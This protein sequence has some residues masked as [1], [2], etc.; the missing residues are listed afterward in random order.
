M[1]IK[2]SAIQLN[3]KAD[4]KHNLQVIEQKLV[5]LTSQNTLATYEQHI[6]VLPECCLF[7]GA[8]DNAQL[9]LAKESSANNDLQVA[10]GALAKK[11]KVTLIAGSIPLL[12]AEGN[13]FTNSS[14]AFNSNGTLIGRYDKIHLFDVNVADSEKTYCESRFTH[15]GSTPY[16]VKTPTV[17]IGLTIC[18]DLRFPMLFQRL[19]AMGADIITVPS[20]FTRVTGKAHWQTLLQARAIE[21]QVYIIAAGQEGV[22]ENGRETWGHSMIISPWGEIL[23]SIEEG[24]GIISSDFLPQEIKRIRASM[25]LMHTAKT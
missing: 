21:N 2:L 22:H 23:A 14:C 3:S 6:V 7:F 19:T 25:P 9:S 10:L 8:R 11:Y 15:A 18:F 4:V 12:T 13:K 17:N 20:A 1:M 5:K 24:E 16:I